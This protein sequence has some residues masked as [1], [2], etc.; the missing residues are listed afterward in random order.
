MRSKRSTR[1]ITQRLTA[2]L[3]EKGRTGVTVQEIYAAFRADR[4]GPA[5]ESS[6][7]AILY[8]RLITAKIPYRPMYERYM[9]GG[10]VRYRMAS[11]AS[12]RI[13]EQQRKSAG[14]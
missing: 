6:I 9:E 3:S 4:Y 2:I 7:R 14:G 5:L 10:S 12:S 1:S 13:H 11:K 8:K